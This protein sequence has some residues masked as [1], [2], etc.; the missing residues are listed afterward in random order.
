MCEHHVHDNCDDLDCGATA[1]VGETKVT[2]FDDLLTRARFI[3]DLPEYRRARAGFVGFGA[4]KAGDRVLL[5]VDTQYDR[6]VVQAVATALR[7]RGAHVDTLWVDY[8][9]DREF[10]YEDE[11]AVLMRRVP[12][13][14]NPRRWEG[15]PWIEEMAER[16]KYDLLIHGKG[17]PVLQNTPY[18]YEQLPWLGRE[19]FTRWQTMYPQE[20]LSAI[21]QTTWDVIWQKGKGGR[22]HLTDPEGTDLTFTLFEDY[23]GTCFGWVPEPKKAYGHLFAHPT[24]P[25]ID[26]VDTTGVAA[27]TTNHFGRPYPTIKAWVEGGCV[28]RI[29]GGAGYGDAWR[30]MLEESRKTQY[31]FFPRPGLFYLFEM[32]IAGHPKIVRPGN[33][34]MLSSGGHEWE[35]QRSGIIHLGFGTMWRHDQEAWAAER[36]ILYGHLHIHLLFPTYELTTREG[37]VIKVIDKG[38]L[39][40]LDDP[41]VRAIAAKYGDPDELLREDW[42]PDIPG[43]NLGGS[44]DDYGRDPASW[45]YKAVAGKI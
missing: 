45:I 13:A 20:L 42:I 35:R 23:Y 9:P 33:I 26:K 17:G 10:E 25:L 7:E 8:G 16:E 2:D 1:Q 39:T 15:R 21:S 29:E 11:I 34:N 4:T 31:P 36:R 3:R 22:V 37:E 14:E 41:K 6:D 40:S 19:H 32:A 27:G 43:I 44:Y 28:Q 5:A 30:D 12:W 18:R 24:I 38:R